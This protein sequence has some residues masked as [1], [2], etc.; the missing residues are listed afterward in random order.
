[1]TSPRLGT[2]ILAV[3]SVA[4]FWIGRARAE[5][6]QRQVWRGEYESKA[7]RLRIE[8]L[9][10]DLV[11]FEF[12][13]ADVKLSG[14]IKPTPMVAKRDYQGPARIAKAED[15][16]LTTAEL[17]LRID[18][19]SLRLSLLDTRIKPARSLTTLS[20]MESQRSA[21]TLAAGRMTHA[22]GLGEQFIE[23]GQPNGDWIG[24]VRTPGCQFGNRMVPFGGGA[25]GNAMFP[26]LYAVG[27][28]GENYAIF[29]DDI[30]AQTW[31]LSKDSWTIQST[32]STI[33]GYLLTGQGDADHG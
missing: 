16:T 28:P 10:D 24:R 6:P 3:L 17:E 22:Y 23:M 27:G 18:P 14:R 32:G 4:V 5:D 11:L 8:I 33:R 21:F 19:A 29:F 2:Y 15:G 25:V 12:V 13:P 7:W 9:D 31:D 20:P 1:M 26:V 30:H